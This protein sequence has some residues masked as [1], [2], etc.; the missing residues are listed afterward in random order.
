[1]GTPLPPQK[2]GRS[3][4]IFGPCLLW[5]NGW[6]IKMVLGMQVGLSPG[7]LVSDGDPSL[8]PKKGTEPLPNFRP[9]SIA[10]KR[11][12]A[13]RC[14]LVWTVEVGLSPGTLLYGEPAPPQKV[15]GA[16]SPILGPCL[17]WPNG[18]MD[19]GSTW[20]GGRPLPRRHCVRWGPSS[21]LQKGGR[22]HPRF[23][24]NFYCGQMDGCIKMPLGME[25]GLSPGD[26]VRWGPSPRSPKKEQSPQFSAHVSRWIKMPLGTEVGRS[27]RDIVLDGDPAPPPL[28]GHSPQFLANV[29]RG[30]TAGRTKMPLGVEVGLGPGD[31]CVR[32]G[33]PEKRAHQP[34]PI[35][36]PCLLWPNGWM[37]EDCIRRRPSSPLKGHSS[38][39]SFQPMSILSYC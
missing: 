7:D 16:P 35:F 37:D 24:V 33:T 3:P 20:H 1:M 28:R 38:R 17:L 30:Q 4:P 5:P 21:P 39:P 34:H 6:M 14:H 18:W 31:F 19:Q 36:G 11:L 10:A 13:S 15:G 12:D 9:I 25:V 29:R 8:L 23:S 27:L 32:S 26:C 22:A 2:R